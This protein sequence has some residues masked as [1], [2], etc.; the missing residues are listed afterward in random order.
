MQTLAQEKNIKIQLNCL[1]G[2]FVHENFVIA[3]INTDNDLDIKKLQKSINNSIHVGHTRLFDEDSR[4]GLISLTEIASRALSPGIN[5]PG[6]AIQIIGSQERLF[7]LWQ[8]EM[9]KAKEVVYDLIEVPEIP[10]ECFF[11]D[12]FRPIARD[13]ANNIE[14]MLRLQ[15]ALTSIATINNGKFKK[16]AL[17]NSEDAYNRAE[18]AIQ[19]TDDLNLLRKKCLF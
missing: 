13:G 11:D 10:I 3:Y 12:A 17:K 15:G 6:T 2:K 5:D 19:F 7:F 16:N 18:K 8:K 1:P 4:L 14:V 9:D